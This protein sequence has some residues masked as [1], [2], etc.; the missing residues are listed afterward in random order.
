V[1]IIIYLSQRKLPLNEGSSCFANCQKKIKTGGAE[2]NR[3]A[4]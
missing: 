1:F 2:Q 4:A 3:T